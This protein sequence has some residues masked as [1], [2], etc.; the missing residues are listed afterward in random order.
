MI[1]AKQ[2][3]FVKLVIW[4][5]VI[6]FV[7]SIFVIAG[8][9]HFGSQQEAK[10][11]K[12]MEDLD[13]RGSITGEDA[14]KVLVSVNDKDITAGDFFK[15]L[16]NMS[17]MD[18]KYAGYFDTK[19]RRLG[20]L[21]QLISI[22][23]RDHAISEIKLT[24]EEID[25]ELAKYYREDIKNKEDL[26]KILE[27]QGANLQDFENS[28]IKPQLQMTKLKDKLVNPRNITEE[29]LK[30]YYEDNKT[31]FVK[32]IKGPDGK[33]LTSQLEYVEAKA[34]VKQAV[35]KDVTDEELKTYFEKHKDRFREDGKVE[36]SQILIKEG[37]K[38]R[39]DTITP[40]DEQLQVYYS[41][42]RHEKKYLTPA[43]MKISSVLVAKDNA[44][45][46][47]KVEVT[48]E[49]LKSNY[50]TNIKEYTVSGY[51][52]ISNILIAIE[53]KEIEVND[54]ILMAKYNEIGKVDC[55]HI[56]VKEETLAVELQNRLETGE[57][58]AELAKEFSTDS[59]KD[60]G[61]EYKGVLRGKMVKPFEDAIFSQK[62]G[63]I[64]PPVKTRFGYHVIRV[65]NTE[66]LYSEPFEAVKA[67]IEENYRKTQPEKLAIDKI[68]NIKKEIKNGLSFSAAAKKYSQA[69]SG[70]TGGKAGRLYDDYGVKN[71]YKIS[72]NNDIAKNGIIAYGIKN[73]AKNLA[74]GEVSDEIKTALGYHLIKVDAK[75]AEV[76]KEFAT[77]KT[78]VEKIVRINKAVS[79]VREKAEEIYERA[80]R[81][82]KF[83]I[84]AK[85]YSDGTQAAEG[86]SVGFISLDEPNTDNSKIIGEIGV[87]DGIID[88]N[89]L[90]ELKVVN[91]ERKVLMPI[92]S[93]LGTNV[94][95][96]DTIDVSKPKKFEI[97]KAELSK[98]YIKFKDSE[99]TKI[100]AE[101]IH[102]KLVEKNDFAEL[103]VEFS[104]APSGAKGG[105]LGEFVKG[106]M[107]SGEEKVEFLKK[108][109][110]LNGWTILPEFNEKVYTQEEGTFCEV[111][112]TKLGYHIFKVDKIIESV[113]PKFED[114]KEEIKKILTE[115]T[116]VT[117]KEI[118]EYYNSNISD[119][120]TDAQI[121][122]KTYICSTKEEAMKYK[123]LIEEGKESFDKLTKDPSKGGDSGLVPEKTYSDELIASV[124]ATKD[125]KIS[126]PVVH[127]NGFIIA[128]LVERK[129]E[130][131][132]P[133]T[134]VKSEIIEKVLEPKKNK[135]FEEYLKELRNKAD[136]KYQ[137]N[138]FR[139][140]EKYKK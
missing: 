81:G 57:D 44:D 58:F 133:V 48:E 60:S 93:A 76:V 134:E 4:V 40:T 83:D 30:K 105:K 103:A 69:P 62:I 42:H 51:A 13:L 36:V 111:T 37:M 25:E 88:S 39:L 121:R 126:E 67:K 82:E 46:L 74:P 71:E 22:K 34:A 140:L 119:Y 54:S 33:D 72:M 89:I 100:L 86:G 120:T 110:M 107:P 90:E 9:V 112:K 12:K 2:N 23:L 129:D 10:Q 132:K 98:D 77:V 118:E 11:K 124:K 91:M 65:D 64:Y 19:E 1:F 109:I 18:P 50:D 53:D 59:N 17:K 137:N 106:E 80:D 139:L 94:I 73:A 14:A 21:E 3:N 16:G 104:D 5:V 15:M 85:N 117:D 70:K 113:E 55:R 26:S 32:T 28:R 29:L 97:V 130:I 45:L 6:S 95:F 49:E 79:L 99:I 78:D 135:M 31:K 43:R 115:Y 127:K 61:G 87:K 138:N 63:E 125:G 84:L 41:D 35:E 136:I 52:D 75:V 116:T 20:F 68:K 108:E 102:K 131:V 7:L 123:K 66:K 27:K 92:D 38:K 56:L 96:V 122:L 8:M 114:H 128:Q 101:D 24:R 47:K